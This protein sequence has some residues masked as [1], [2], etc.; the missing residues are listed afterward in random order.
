VT[1]AIPVELT[2]VDP[3]T[4]PWEL[5]PIE[6]IAANLEHVPLM[7]DPETPPYPPGL[8]PGRELRVVSRGRD[9]GARRHS[10]LSAGWPCDPGSVA[11]SV[12]VWISAEASVRFLAPQ[13]S[14]A[15]WPPDSAVDSGCAVDSGYWGTPNQPH[16]PDQPRKHR[17]SVDSVTGEADDASD[18]PGRTGAAHPLTRSGGARAFRVWRCPAWRIRR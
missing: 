8:V 14:D 3:N 4:A 12:A 1:E 10:L 6:H 9:H 13:T 18:W 15:R 11:A 17:R 7:S 16:N 2:V 5:F